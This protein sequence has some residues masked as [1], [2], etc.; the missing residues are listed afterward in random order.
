[1]QYNDIKDYKYAKI[2]GQDY[3]YEIA[4]YGADAQGGKG[5]VSSIALREPDDSMAWMSIDEV[6][7][8]ND[9]I[10]GNNPNNLFKRARGISKNIEIRY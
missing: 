4:A 9:D 7:F 10:P 2:K 8:I 5:K 3:T 1:M 6:E